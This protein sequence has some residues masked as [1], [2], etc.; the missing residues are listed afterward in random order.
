MGDR[1]QERVLHL[2]ERPQA[3]RGV[4][5]SLLALAE[6][7]LGEL[8]LRDVED[9]AL[10][11]QRRAVVGMEERGL[12]VHPDRA[13]VGGMQAILGAPRHPRRRREGVARPDRIALG[14][15]HEAEPQLGVL[16]PLLRRH[17]RDLEDLGADVD[18]LHAGVR[19]VEIDRG[20]HVLDDAAVALFGFAEPSLGRLLA[21]HVVHDALGEQRRPLFVADH[22]RLVPDP[23]PTAVL[24]LEPVF[25]VERFQGRGVGTDRI[26]RPLA[27]VGVQTTAPEPI[28]RSPLVGSVP[29]DRGNLRAHVDR[30]GLLA[31]R[32]D[33]RH[34]RKRLDQGSVSALGVVHRLLGRL[35]LSDVDQEPVAEPRPSI[36][37]P[38]D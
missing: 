27:I 25:G 3:L 18:R 17:S 16:Q 2:V 28:G 34:R 29:E 6:G 33:I 12:V 15:I 37:V 21:C 19:P 10:E 26:E 23:H 20:G 22:D 36:L 4:A 35:A 30:D 9:D 13:S 32:V 14:R 1:R 24:M 38:D 11:V 7:L 5:L 8:P 31:Q